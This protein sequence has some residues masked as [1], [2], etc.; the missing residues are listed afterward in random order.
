[1]F[2]M[3]PDAKTLELGG[4]DNPLPGVTVNVDKRPGPYT[5]FT[6][7][8]DEPLPITSDEFDGVV[9]R[10][11][12]EHLSWRKVR[13]FVAEIHRVLK[14]G[15]KVLVITA[16]VEAQ[17]QWIKDNPKGW[18]DKPAFE[19]ASCILFGDQDYPE[20]THKNY[21]SPDIVRGLFLE[22]GFVNVVVSAFGGRQT[23]LRLDADKVG[24]LR[25]LVEKVEA[26]NEEFD[27][28]IFNQTNNK[29]DVNNAVEDELVELFREEEKKKRMEVEERGEK[30]IPLPPEG[31]L[32]YPKTIFGPAPIDEVPAF[33]NVPKKEMPPA[34]LYDKHYF[35][36]GK[37][38]GG[39]AREG[40]W[41][42]P[43]H[44]T[45]AQKILDRKPESVLELG[46]A[47]GYVLKR[48]QDAGVRG[49]GIEVS[50]H[51]YMTRVC[52]GIS[53]QSITDPWRY[54]PEGD[55]DWID[56][57]YSVAVLEHIPESDLPHVISEMVRC[58]KRG[59]HG[60][61]FGHKD[62][63][64]DKTHC[65][66]RER[67]WW[68]AKFA[69]LAPRYPVEIVDKEELEQGPPPP[70]L[71]EG[72]GKVKLNIGCHSVMFFYSWENIDILDMSQWADQYHYKFKRLDV[73]N[74]LPYGTGSV[75]A[76]FS[77][78]MLE[79]LSYADG[80]KFLRE[81]RRVLKPTGVIR[82]LVP[83]AEML[84]DM[85]ANDSPRG[86]TFFDQFDH[87]NDECEKATS[88]AMKLHCL[89]NENH[90]A[91]YDTTTLLDMMCRAG[92]DSAP[93]SLHALPPLLEENKEMQKQ[94]L[95]ET[96]DMFP[97]LSLIVAGVP[98]TQ[99]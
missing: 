36:G 93:T 43:C 94:L 68:V 30:V 78:H 88:K 16:D 24:S 22:A 87:I 62:D 5:S 76:I 74:G 14:P 98:R 20:N 49:Y 96:H 31:R 50:K 45:T 28:M 8:F 17:V 63:G 59:L 70:G 37:K 12:L 73:R 65:L 6:A 41:D 91:T 81:C 26:E 15:G 40:Y 23:D 1:M 55:E 13:Q 35:N 85:Y 80:L 53:N 77:S 84:M 54:V 11:V 44:F 33:P 42:Y 18:D 92:F 95:R 57:V 48:I 89:L 4:G 66:L 39:Y 21:M 27:K 7:D 99:A 52:E 10:F 56:L 51:C 47:R 58:S 2:E 86:I 90:L 38:V 29:G 69:E 64:F 60:I 75:D 97:C 19:S 46:C 71:I 9:S 67:S 72:D 34:E 61:D 82:I 83:D 32:N 25:E 79:H 3:P